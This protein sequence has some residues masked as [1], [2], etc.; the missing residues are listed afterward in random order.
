LKNIV[1]IGN[2]VWYDPDNDGKYEPGDGEQG[3]NGIQVLLYRDANGNGI[4]EPDAADGSAIKTTTTAQMTLD[5]ELHD[6]I[7]QFLDLTPSTPGD[8]T[9]NYFVA[10]L[11]S[12]LIA[13]GYGYSSTG[14]SS[15]PLSNEDTDDGYPLNTTGLQ[16]SSYGPQSIA[17]STYV[18]SNPFVVTK[19]GQNA[20][21]ATDDWGDA[22]GYAD[23]SS[24]MTVDFGFTPGPNA[25][26]LTTMGG[27]DH[28]ILWGLGM[29]FFG[30]VGGAG[31][32]A[33]R[34]HS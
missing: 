22:V 21:I 32:F 3:I 29:M 17:A 14:Y 33:W 7:Y 24:Y 31:A 9:T 23:I 18:V 15:Q 5:G 28:T 10:V 27:E 12:D 11:S 20:S 2:L 34:R 4:P 26:T 6:G 16:A 8:P 30:V 13:Q 19:G 1:A 25:V